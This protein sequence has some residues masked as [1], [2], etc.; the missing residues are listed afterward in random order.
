MTDNLALSHPDD[1]KSDNTML[2]LPSPAPLDNLTLSPASPA[3]ADNR[4]LSRLCIAC[5]NTISSR[6][7]A[8]CSE[9]CLRRV[10]RER[11]EHSFEE[12]VGAVKRQLRAM[13]RAAGRGRPDAGVFEELLLLRGLED[14]FKSDLRTA[15]IGLRARG[16][17]WGQIGRTFGIS[18]QGAR[19]RWGVQ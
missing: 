10:R 13:A 6:R 1:L 9:R 16:A 15:I 2:S 8:Y 4:K 14:E 7:R 17:D 3:E 12:K 19:Q 11:R 18:R 5:G